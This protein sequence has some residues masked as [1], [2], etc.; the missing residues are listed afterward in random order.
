MD[1]KINKFLKNKKY[2]LA[3]VKELSGKYLLYVDD[4]KAWEEDTNYGEYEESNDATYKKI[5]ILIEGYGFEISNE[6]DCT[7]RYY[8]LKPI[9]RGSNINDD[10]LFAGTTLNDLYEFLKQIRSNC[11][12]CM[13]YA[14]TNL[15]KDLKR[16]DLKLCYI[17][18]GVAY[19]TNNEEQ[20]GDD[21]ND[22]PYEHNAGTPYK[23][24]GYEVLKIGFY[25]GHKYSE[26]CDYF[27]SNHF[28]VEEINCRFVPWLIPNS[29]KIPPVFAGESI[30][31]F[32]KKIESV[33]GFLL[34]PLEISN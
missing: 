26:P 27:Y 19:F 31:D 1:E 15:K 11:I 5:P 29:V 3:T 33:N 10:K 14:Y 4:L 20:W 22:S 8:G 21:W 25:V 9:L 2:K 23:E 16:K 6:Y 17:D 30:K 32:S 18:E 24:D 13:P 12:I 7:G 34:Y 28:S